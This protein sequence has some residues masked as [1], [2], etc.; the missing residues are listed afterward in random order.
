MYDYSCF[1]YIYIYIVFLYMYDKIFKY[2]CT[3][4]VVVIFEAFI[5]QFLLLVM[6]VLIVKLVRLK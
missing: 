5:A 2:L 1:L 4:I 6:Q 3:F